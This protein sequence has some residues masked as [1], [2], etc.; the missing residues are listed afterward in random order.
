MDEQEGAIQSSEEQGGIKIALKSEPFNTLVGQFGV[1][2]ASSHPASSCGWQLVD[3]GYIPYNLYPAGSSLFNTGG[4]NNN[5]GYSSP[6]EDDLVNATEYGSS[7]QAF[8]QYENYTADQLP[9][10]WLPLESNVWVYKNNLG[11]FA[12]LNPISGGLNP[13]DWYYTK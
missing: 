5:G 9:W 8:F 12:P 7:T 6:E 11:G 13:E 4:V 10:L 1:C 2:T 3:E